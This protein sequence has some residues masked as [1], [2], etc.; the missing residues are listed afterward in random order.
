[1]NPRPEDEQPESASYHLSC[2]TSR[3]LYSWPTG[4]N[5]VKNVEALRIDCVQLKY[6]RFLY[7]QDGM[8]WAG[9]NGG[10]RWSGPY[11]VVWSAKAWQ[12]GQGVKCGLHTFYWEINTTTWRNTRSNKKQFTE[13]RW[14]RKTPQPFGLKKCLRKRN[15]ILTHIYIAV[16][17]VGTCPY[18]T[19]K[20]HFFKHS[21]LSQNPKCHSS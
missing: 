7:K 10:W 11:R 14:R 13:M 12:P 18:K 9:G 6:F 15:N 1:M 21:H 5:I 16:C 8:W 19:K 17:S 20:C 4:Q 3:L 2:G